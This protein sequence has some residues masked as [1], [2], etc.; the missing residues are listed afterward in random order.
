MVLHM[1][2]LSSVLLLTTLLSACSLAPDF[3]L[4]DMPLPEAYKEQPTPIEAATEQRGSWKKAENLEEA[5][6]GLWWK[7]YGD[8]SL[9]KLEEEAITAN[10]SLK[11]AAARVEQSRGIAESN[12]FSFLPNFDIAANA[13]RSKPSNASLAAFGNSGVTLKPY[14]LFS[15]RGVLS[16]EADLFGKVRDSY[17][18]FLLEAD[19]RSADYN[20]ILLA[21]Q[22]DVAS[23][24]FSIRA[25]DSEI[26]LLRDTLEI[27]E[28]A[29]R[30]MQRQYDVGAAGEADLTRT[31]S[32]LSSTKAEQISLERQRNALEHALAVLLGKMPSE[33]SLASGPL[34]G[35]PPELPPGLPSTLLER[36]PDI[37]GARFAMEAANARIGVARAA[38]F[39]DIT[40]TAN[41]GFE[42]TQ[43]GDVFKWSSRAWA[44]GQVGGAAI[45]MPIFDAG[46]NL[47]RL[48][49]A[50]AAH[51]EAV[52]NYRQ[53]VLQG[54]RDV[55][56]NL[57]D[58]RLLATQSQA[59][60][61]ASSA[62]AR[63]TEVLQTRYDEGDITFFE[64]V[65]AQR[66]S[67]AAE[68]TAVRVRGQR[69]LTSIALVRALGGGWNTAQAKQPTPAETAPEIPAEVAAATPLVPKTTKEK[70][71]KK[72]KKKAAPKAALPKTKKTGRTA[73]LPPMPPMFENAVTAPAGMPTPQSPAE[74]AF[75]SAVQAPAS[76]QEVAPEG[77]YP[78]GNNRATYSTPLNQ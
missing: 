45:A 43:L 9:N 11:A 14:N 16:Y 44:L 12:T 54:F 7:V 40:L 8:E 51:E 26:R 56:D 30:I 55:E 74:A 76:K 23:N 34:I 25:I 17:K 24:Y 10:Q 75:E 73:K 49:A 77:N 72:S 60:D 57:S 39:P 71:I 33:L 2:N 1:R 62:S 41:G 19:A 42:S 38:F 64:V 46:R 66:N 15:T 18:S 53:T 6:K 29:M 32:E 22:A 78:S 58:Q 35:S 61:A 27:R 70:T 52:A 68:R 13:V 50:H 69:F 48:D 21:L 5:D 67:L 63:T 28:K 20:N 47:S 4:P 65:D 37:A 3:K 31:M 36:R 59:Q